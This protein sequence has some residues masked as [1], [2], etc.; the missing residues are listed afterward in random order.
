MANYRDSCPAK[1]SKGGWFDLFTLLAWRDSFQTFSWE[2]IIPVPEL[3]I[4][5]INPLLALV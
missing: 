2:Q 1:T 4:K 3:A 5:Q